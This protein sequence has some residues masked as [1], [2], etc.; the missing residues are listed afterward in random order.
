MIRGRHRQFSFLA[1][2]TAVFF[3]AGTADAGQYTL[4]RVGEL[5]GQTIFSVASFINASGQIV[6]EMMN[7][8]GRHYFFWQPDAP[9]SPTGV[10]KDFAL[11]AG[12]SD[13]QPAYINSRGQITGNFQ[14]LGSSDEHLFLWT[15]AGDSGVFTDLGGYLESPDRNSNSP[16]GINDYGQV[17]FVGNYETDVDPGFGIRTF[18]WTPQTPNGSTG[19]FI[20]IGNLPNRQFTHAN[21]MNNFGQVVGTSFNDNNA[22]EN[23]F[24][25]TPDVPNGTT[26]SMVLIPALKASDTFT[27]PVGMNSR[28]QFVGES[29]SGNEI[30][31]RDGFLW[32]PDSS[33][34]TTGSMI[35]LGHMS[36]F[37]G[38]ILPYSVNDLGQVVGAASSDSGAEQHAFFWTAESG[39]VDLHALLDQSGANW[40]LTH[41]TAINQAGQIIGWGDYDPDG[42]GGAEPV[43][44]AFLLTPNTIPEPAALG[45]LGA[46]ALL[47]CARPSRRKPAAITWGRAE[48]CNP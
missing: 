14:T 8:T 37:E 32:T 21:A 31:D 23:V 27:L 45:L 34:G 35:N 38:E 36:G 6:G 30:S 4:T 44:S 41:A 19:S 9:N 33:N 29:G 48:F 25:W 17:T 22:D 43:S 13:L 39:M 1:A 15:P 16:R 10:T 40:V 7:E 24:L 3:A 46:G 42:P 20:D 5:P 47:A 2:A 11:L 18:M 26:G 12:K 28:G